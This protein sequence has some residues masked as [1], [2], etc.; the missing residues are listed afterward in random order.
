[1]CILRFAMCLR[2]HAFFTSFNDVCSRFVTRLQVL[3][4]SLHKV[5]QTEENTP[6]KFT[7]YQHKWK[8]WIFTCSVSAIIGYNTAMFHTH[9]LIV[10]IS[11]YIF[12]K[13]GITENW[14]I[15]T[16]KKKFFLVCDSAM[17]SK[18][19]CTYDAE[20]LCEGSL[21]PLLVQIRCTNFNF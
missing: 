14:S 15:C 17:A 18:I 1:M 7:H 5:V 6:T 20:N 11:Y 4:S 3:V 10:L 2:T 19:Y 16:N 13:F 8:I 21:T 9:S 12:L